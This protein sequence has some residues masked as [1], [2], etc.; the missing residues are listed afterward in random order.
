MVLQ[1]Q[2]PDGTWHPADGN[3][4]AMYAVW[5]FPSQA[6]RTAKVSIKTTGPSLSDMIRENFRLA[7]IT[8]DVLEEQ[9]R[10]SEQ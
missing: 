10:L 4:S 6:H 7:G 9:F 3:A 8:E 2:G 5:T 1:V